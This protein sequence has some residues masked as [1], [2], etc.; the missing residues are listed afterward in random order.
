MA[1]VFSV[2]S[3]G[4]TVRPATE[5]DHERANM[6]AAAVHLAGMEGNDP[7]SLAPARPNNAPRR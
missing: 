3:D 4:I 1:K 6:F 7:A 5:A 2:H